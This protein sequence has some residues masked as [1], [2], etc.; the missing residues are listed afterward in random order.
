M[1]RF[2]CGFYAASSSN[3]YQTAD[4]A[5]NTFSTDWLYMGVRKVCALHSRAFT[6]LPASQGAITSI[7]ADKTSL[8]CTVPSHPSG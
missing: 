1:Q 3:A 4:S 5:S 7:S 2:E 8:Q 6:A